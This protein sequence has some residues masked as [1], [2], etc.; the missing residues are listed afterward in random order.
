[1]CWWKQL[2]TA[3]RLNYEA[4]PGLGPEKGHTHS[5][6]TPPHAKETAA[7][8]L[9]LVERLGKGKRAR[10][11]VGTGHG[12]CTCQG[13]AFEYRSLLHNDLSDRGLRVRVE[14]RWVSNEPCPGD[15]GFDGFE[16]Q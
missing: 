10:I 6:C 2:A 5:V 15:F 14:L 9:D 13:A 3:P 7:A 4:I 8:Y 16:I 12:S 11:V 1:M